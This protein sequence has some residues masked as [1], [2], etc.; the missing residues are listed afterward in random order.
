[1]LSAVRA[2]GFLSGVEVAARTGY[3]GHRVDLQMR[4]DVMRGVLDVAP[5]GYSLTQS[6]E[7][8]LEQFEQNQRASGKALPLVGD[9]Q[10]TQE[11]QWLQTS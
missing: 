3:A 2:A 5:S 7:D 8:L 10:N 11:P 4:R 6:G 9:D 1:M